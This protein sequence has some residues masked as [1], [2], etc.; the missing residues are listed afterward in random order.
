M[1]FLLRFCVLMLFKNA[2]S[3]NKSDLSKAGRQ[4]ERQADMQTGKQTNR[5]A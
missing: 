3:K 5:Q 4:T 1:L 2:S